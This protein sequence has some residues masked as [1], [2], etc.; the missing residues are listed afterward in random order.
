M[1]YNSS[2]SGNLRA[3]QWTE[4][5][6]VIVLLREQE[7]QEQFVAFAV[8]P[9]HNQLVTAGRNLLLRLWDLETFTCLRTIKVRNACS[10]IR[11]ILCIELI[12]CRLAC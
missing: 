9:G 12:E 5:I 10:F 11:L 8:R 6:F 7:Q 4:C 3:H 2:S 1:R